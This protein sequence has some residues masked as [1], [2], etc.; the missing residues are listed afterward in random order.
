MSAGVCRMS[1]SNGGIVSRKISFPVE[2]VVQSTVQDGDNRGLWKLLSKHRTQ[3]LDLDYTN[4]IGLTAL[5]YSVLGN[6]LDAAKMLLTNGA[7]ANI[8]DINGY[9]PL[10]T[11]AACGFLQISSLLILFGAN[12]FVETH[13]GDLPVDLAKHT[14]MAT[15]LHDQMLAHL[16]RDLYWESFLATKGSQLWSWL[17]QTSAYT[18]CRLSDFL[19]A[20]WDLLSTYYHRERETNARRALTE[21]DHKA[22][23]E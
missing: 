8:A 9:T 12:L 3:A 15:F 14:I 17:A 23:D 18:L 1:E 19:S 4:H 16:H 2:A 10:H 11:A 22:K 21:L 7:D 6:N 5:H 20:L 13:D